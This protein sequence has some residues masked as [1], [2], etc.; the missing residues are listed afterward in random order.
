MRDDIR[1]WFPVWVT[2]AYDT[3]NTTLDFCLSKR[4]WRGQI[5]TN[6]IVWHWGLAWQFLQDSNIGFRVWSASSLSQPCKQ[7]RGILD[8]YSSSKWRRATLTCRHLLTLCW[9]TWWFQEHASE[10][11]LLG[12]VMLPFC[13]SA[14]NFRFWREWWIRFKLLILSV[15]AN[16]ARRSA[17]IIGAN[18]F[19]S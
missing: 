2:A 17:I 12:L 14:L 4:V 10:W 13:S 1:I 3:I 7:S 9:Y 5:Y 19:I 6:W 15:M 16:S 11:T 8:K 18:V